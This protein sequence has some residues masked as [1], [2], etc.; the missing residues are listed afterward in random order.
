MNGLNNIEEAVAELRENP[1]EER[2]WQTVILFQN[3]PFY[4]V[5]GLPFSYTVKIG[6]SGKYTH[7]L[8]INRREK[9]KT[10]TWSSVLLA[11]RKALEKQG[12]VITRPKG[13]VD[14]RGIS[15]SFSILWRFGLVAVP[16]E[17]EKKMQDIS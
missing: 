8:I 6:R 10:L 9:S 16:E 12:T 1:T 13:L 11:F 4:T 3:Y 17:L 14:C 5:S 7:E 2:L 15:Y